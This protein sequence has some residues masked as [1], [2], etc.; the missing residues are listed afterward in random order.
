MTELFTCH[1]CGYPLSKDQALCPECGQTAEK[2]AA[3]WKIDGT[4]PTPDGHA[5]DHAI[6]AWLVSLILSVAMLIVDVVTR[7]PSVAAWFAIAPAV[8]LIQLRVFLPL[9]LVIEDRCAREV[10]AFFGIG[11]SLWKS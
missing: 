6:G 10:V 7:G 5:L 3:A 2:S 1:Q 4:G 8:N 9:A 11:E